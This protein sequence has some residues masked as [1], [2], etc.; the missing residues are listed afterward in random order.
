MTGSA[1]HLSLLAVDDDPLSIDLV[2]DALKSLD[3]NIHRAG[4]A[5]QARE[6]F[7]R[8]KPQ[9]VLLDLKLPDASGLELLEEFTQQVPA[10]DV[11]LLTGHYTPES[12]VEAI[13]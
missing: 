7:A 13:R 2:V 4:T 3:V 10:T 9:A 6:L 5:A 12:A 1:F 8:F 11:I